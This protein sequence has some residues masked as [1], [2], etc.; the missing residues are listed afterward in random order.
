MGAALLLRR[1][2]RSAAVHPNEIQVELFGS[3]K[4]N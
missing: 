1:G 3:S 4:I 2:I